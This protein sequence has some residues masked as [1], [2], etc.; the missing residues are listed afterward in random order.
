[1]NI[2]IQQSKLEHSLLLKTTRN[3]LVFFLT[4]LKSAEFLKST[5]SFYNSL[6]LSSLFFPETQ[7]RARMGPR[8]IIN[9][10]NIIF[11]EIPLNCCKCSISGAMATF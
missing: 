6:K 9:C 2:I 5:V 7:C 11:P 3:A 10:D 4:R 8:N 1:M